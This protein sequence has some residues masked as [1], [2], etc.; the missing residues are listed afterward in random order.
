MKRVVMANCSFPALIPELE[1]QWRQWFAR[2]GLDPQEVLVQPIIIDDDAR[3]IE[4][5]M[6]IRNAHGMVQIARDEFGHYKDHAVFETV[7]IQL[8]APA[9]PVPEGYDVVITE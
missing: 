8:E 1:A 5:E 6:Y 9:L 2:H 7:T 4:V 3:T